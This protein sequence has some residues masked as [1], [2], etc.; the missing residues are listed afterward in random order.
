MIAR[1]GRVILRNQI[2]SVRLSQPKRSHSTVSSN[3][4]TSAQKPKSSLGKIVGATLIVSSIYTGVTVYASHDEQLREFY[5]KNMPLGA[6][7]IEQA[8]KLE[9]FVKVSYPKVKESL[10][11]LYEDLKKYTSN[12]DTSKAETSGKGLNDFEPTSK[13]KKVVNEPVIMTQT[14]DPIVLAQFDAIAKELKQI[15][16]EDHILDLIITAT[17]E[18]LINLDSNSDSTSDLRKDHQKDV[19]ST[20]KSLGLLLRELKSKDEDSP[21]NQID[22]TPLIEEAVAKERLAAEATSRQ[23]IQGLQ[24]NFD[25]EKQALINQLHHELDAKLAQQ[26]QHL[27]RW[28]RR[29]SK[30]LVDRE[31]N[32]RLSKLNNALQQL[33]LLESAIIT[34]SQNHSKTGKLDQLSCAI[35]ALQLAVHDDSSRPFVNELRHL[36]RVSKQFP[37][38]SS[39]AASLDNEVARTGLLTLND[40]RERFDFVRLE[41]SRASLVPENAGLA[42]HLTSY[43][44]SSLLFSKSESS[45][46][47]DIESILARTQSYL[48]KGDLLSATS[49]LNQVKGWPKKLAMD[50]LHSAVKRLEYDQALQALQTEVCLE[51]LARL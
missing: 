38:A 31:R 33:Y 49:E 30:L 48:S 19:L 3:L 4:K 45:T 34:A 37:I 17:H 23:V 43:A 35:D 41:V 27:E 29:E 28:W 20:F 32:Q 50:W 36:Q 9:D 44:L 18:Y 26:A 16:P 12:S 22:P 47:T 40:L 24:S 42:G 2:P 6:E 51:R 1:I 13:I 10:I 14:I 39:V 8:S 25:T 5:I 7:S 15:S 11:S 21:T 46:G